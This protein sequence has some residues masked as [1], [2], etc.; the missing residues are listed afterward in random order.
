MRL[1]S[2]D[3]DAGPG[4]KK[5]HV[6]ILVSTNFRVV[7]EAVRSKVDYYYGIDDLTIYDNACEPDDSCDFEEDVCL[8]SKEGGDSDSKFYWT[9]YRSY[10]KTASF[11]PAIDHTRQSATGYYMFVQASLDNAGSVARLYSQVFAS[12]SSSYC[13]N[14]W[15]YMFGNNLGQLKVFVRNSISSSSIYNEADLWELDGPTNDGWNLAQ[16]NISRDYTRKPFVVII[17]ATIGSTLQGAFGVDDTQFEMSDCGTHPSAAIVTADVLMLPDC[18]FDDGTMCDWSVVGS[19][20]YTFV[21]TETGGAI[22]FDHNGGSHHVYM[23]ASGQKFNTTAQLASPTFIS[24]QH[25]C[26]SFY[27]AMY[28]RDVNRLNVYVAQGQ[29]QKLYWT[30]SGNQ[31][32]GWHHQTMEIGQGPQPTQ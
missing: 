26:L 29:T 23:D 4:W 18:N 27:Y 32:E 28:G 15:Y 25:I 5:A 31:G 24:D 14:F 6:P 20:K 8:W 16:V 10:E 11:A 19:W 30:L 13:F 9:R 21:V 22:P 7:F 12:S 1:W 17:Q 3:F 2:Q